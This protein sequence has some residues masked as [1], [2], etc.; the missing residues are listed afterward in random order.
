[1]WHAL[2]DEKYVHSLSPNAEEKRSFGARG[3]LGQTGINEAGSV[4]KWIGY[5][6]LLIRVDGGIFLL[7][8]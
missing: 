3:Y 5:I 6:W 7:I 4:R 2:D 1:M 8:R